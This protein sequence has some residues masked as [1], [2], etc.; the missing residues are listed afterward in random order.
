MADAVGVRVCGPCT[1]CC[2]VFRILELAKPEKEHCAFCG[3][4]GCQNYEHRPK[5]CADY[6]CLW[7][8]P[9]AV[10]LG[11]PDWTRPD[12]TG[13]VLQS[14]GPDLNKEKIKVFEVWLGAASDYW[15]YKLIKRLAR[16]FKLRVVN[17]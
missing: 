10:E 13:L 11:L 14:D 4:G 5:E 1:A 7:N 8:D 9:K 6:Y 17:A 12:R 2:T 16:R 15:G 3:N